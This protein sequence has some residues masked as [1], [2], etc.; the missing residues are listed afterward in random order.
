M[1][2]QDHMDQ[3]YLAEAAEIAR[4]GVEP[5]IPIFPW[6]PRVRVSGLYVASR[7]VTPPISAPGPLPIQPIP[8]AQPLPGIVPTSA[9]PWQI[10]ELLPWGL[11]REELRL[12]VDGRYPQM[13]ASGTLYGVLAK[14]V[15]WI[16]R[17][18]ASGP[19]AWT[20]SIW[21]KDGDVAGFPYTTVDITTTSTF[22]ASQRKAVVRLSGGGTAVRTRTLAFTSPYFRQVEFE[23][24][25]AAG[26]TAT[27][28]IG[29]HDHPNRPA[30]LPN[31]TLSIEEWAGL[32]EQHNR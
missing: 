10:E 23:F 7:I 26:V 22:L 19:N 15:H 21:F 16:A 25:C 5:L 2:E 18:T 30:T 8:I 11:L 9:G 32:V 3:E 1:K 24:E 6:P 27:T 13:M 17:L 31:E 20:G 12:D 14:R 29:T 4:P 28:P